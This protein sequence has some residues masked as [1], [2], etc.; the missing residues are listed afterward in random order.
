MR[1]AIV[2]ARFNQ[3]VTSRLVGGAVDCIVA[4]GGRAAVKDVVW[5][6]GAFEL[7]LAADL[8]LS[9][10]RY[11]AVVCLGAVI[12]GETPHFEY[13]SAECARG[14]QDVM[15]RRQR[16]VAFGVLTTNTP[17]QARARAGGAA[18][19]KGW[20]AA[21]AAIEMAALVRKAGRRS[22]RR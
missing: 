2:A 6:P 19:N 18:G 9:R 12:R 8:L 10:G 1:I 16:P 20:D 11:E 15:L 5:V 21:L 7:P 4:H 22:S 13:V 17:R 14:V 3:E